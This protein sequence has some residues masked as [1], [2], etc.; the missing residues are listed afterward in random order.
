MVFGFVSLQLYRTG[1]LEL[2]N[3]CNYHI[4]SLSSNTS[5]ES[6]FPSSFLPFFPH[7]SLPSF[8]IPPLPSSLPHSFLIPSLPSS[9]LPFLPHSPTPSSFHPFLPHSSPSFLTPPL[10]PH[11]PSFL[12]PPLLPHSSSFLIPPLPSSLPHSFLIPLH[13]SLLPFLL[14]SSISVSPPHLSNRDVSTAW[15]NNFW[16]DL[17][18]LDIGKAAQLCSAYFTSLLCIE[19]WNEVQR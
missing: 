9:F 14:H 1:R 11:S 7:S 18:F 6:L 5:L 3:C 8:L 19:I 4:C 13:S 16:L 17:D 12:I 15:D 10:L 2:N